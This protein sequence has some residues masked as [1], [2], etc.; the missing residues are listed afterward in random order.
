MSD[1]NFS[2]VIVLSLFFGFGAN[3]SR[4]VLIK[5]FLYTKKACIYTGNVKRI[6]R[7]LENHDCILMKK[8]SKCF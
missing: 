5:L 4:G 6:V 3:L 8:K 2:L 7:N 1:E